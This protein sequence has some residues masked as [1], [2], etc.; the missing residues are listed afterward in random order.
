MKKGFNMKR[1]V[2]VTVDEGRWW[3]VCVQ[4]ANLM[5]LDKVKI[6]ITGGNQ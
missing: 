5:A 3:V 4:E 1:G 2:R 6:K